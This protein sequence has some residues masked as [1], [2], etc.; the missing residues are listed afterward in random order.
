APAATLPAITGAR[1]FFADELLPD[2]RHLDRWIIVLLH[3]P[4][5]HGVGLRLH[6]AAVLQQRENRTELGE[7]HIVA[8]IDAG[9]RAPDPR[10]HRTDREEVGLAAHV[11]PGT[12]HVAA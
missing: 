12:D 1:G 6:S 11:A 9:A 2:V 4:G 7:L 3:Q 8:E 5:A 10:Q